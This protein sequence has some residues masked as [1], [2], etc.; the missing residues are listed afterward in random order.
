MK[1]E[2]FIDFLTQFKDT[3]K[4]ENIYLDEHK[5]DNLM[6]YL[7]EMKKQNPTILF[8]GEAPGYLGCGITGVPF[9][10]ERVLAAKE[11]S[12]VPGKQ[13]Y[14]LS[15][16]QKERSAKAMWDV[17]NIIASNEMIL[18]LMWNSFPFHPHDQGNKLSNRAP[19]KEERENIGI[20]CMQK[21]LNLFDIKE[22][23]A[24]G[25]QAFYSLSD[26]KLGSLFNQEKNVSYIRHPSYGGKR[27]CQEKIKSIFNITN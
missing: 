27:I 22:V 19:N 5:R 8:V 6:I 21:L 12:Y 1:I 17:L 9:T 2:E 15:G 13:L 24:I 23:Y 26:M 18:P 16:A 14:Y 25:L 10:D 3:D 11:Y 4:Y 20:P 7:K